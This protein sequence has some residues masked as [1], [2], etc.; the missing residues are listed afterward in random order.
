MN[1]VLLP[2]N[3][4]TSE[5]SSKHPDV[6]ML[7]GVTPQSSTAALAG[8]VPK[9]SSRGEF[10]TAHSDL[11]GTFPETPAIEESQF[12]VNPI[13]ATSGLGNPVNLAP[14]EK[15]PDPSTLTSNTISSTVRDDKPP[16][17]SADDSNQIFGVA[18]LP[19]TSGAG[20]PINLQPGEKVPDSSTFNNNTINSS[21]TTDKESYE[22]GSG[23]P[24]LPGVVTPEN[25]REARGGGMFNLPAKSKNMIP[26]SSLP[27]GGASSYEK[28]PGFTIQSAGAQ[29]TTAGLA[30]QVPLE[31]RGVPEVVQ[32]S[33]A[34]AGP[35]DPAAS[36]ENSTGNDG[37][38][39]KK[40]LSGGDIAGMAAGGLAGAAGAV[41]IAS[42]GSKDTPAEDSTSLPSR[43]L[44]PSVQQ[45]INEMNRGT[46]IAP[47]V[48]DPVQE[49]IAESH[50]SPEAASSK[51][52][53][54]EKSEVENQ[55]LKQVKTEDM[56][57]EPAPALERPAGELDQAT[58]VSPTLPKVVQESIADAKWSPEAAGNKEAVLEKSQVE[59]SLLKQTKTEDMAGEPA[60]SSTAALS[61]TAPGAP[62]A[63]TKA[64]SPAA[65]PATTPAKQ[66]AMAQA[67]SKAKVDSRDVSPMS[68]GA[69]TASQTQPM[70]TTG[71]GAS[72]TSQTSAATSS[73]T[74][75]KAAVGQS[76]PSP[77]SS[78]GASTDKKSK[79]AS[80]F[81][82]KLKQKFHDKDKDK[83]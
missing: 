79:R 3:I 30:G 13:P 15:V 82:G 43:G 54:R 31:P 73:L 12:S 74:P 4:T 22:R 20:N 44:P 48:P 63:S 41:G 26:E 35:E 64:P 49:S 29:S 45:S 11:P 27:M 61:E 50:W 60:P 14:G 80:G 21:V 25:E 81:F 1:N 16:E 37:S 34:E 69:G 39:D 62:D 32:E 65:A 53:V 51:E 59:Q 17:K 68:K 66:S 23:A 10:N 46:A 47:T 83:K 56:A 71:V 67:V 52:A 24:Q 72:P 70:V 57:G 9:E 28:D 33:Q 7:S 2:E 5:S 76:N 8:K 58:A 36:E 55:L 18:P 38:A 42:H 75:Q 78:A 19:A 6:A 40:G 77:S